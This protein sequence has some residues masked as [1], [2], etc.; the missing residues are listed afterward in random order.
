MNCEDKFLVISYMVFC[1]VMVIIV[2]LL[3]VGEYLIVSG[4]SYFAIF[5]LVTYLQILN[6]RTVHTSFKK[7]RT[8][9]RRLRT[10]AQLQI[11]ESV[12]EA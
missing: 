10:E 3:L 9:L 12:E 7:A 4:V 2:W 11:T 8:C 5:L 1:M 6:L